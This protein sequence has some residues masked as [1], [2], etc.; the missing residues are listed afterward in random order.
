MSDL[1]IEVARRQLGMATH[2]YLRDFDPVSVHCLA[3]AGCELMHFCARKLSCKAL[4]SLAKL[5]PETDFATLRQL[6]R[7]YWIAFKH[8]TELGKPDEERDDDELLRQFMDEKNDLALVIGWADYHRATGKIPIEAQVQQ[9]WYFALH[10]EKHGA[11]ELAQKSLIA[12]P[13][14]QTKSR[15]EQKRLLNVWIRRA[16]A[17]T[18]TMSHPV[19][20]QRPLGAGMK[21]Q[22]AQ[23][24]ISIDAKPRSQRDRNDIAIEVGGVSQAQVSELRV[25]V[26]DLQSGEVTV[27]G[28]QAR[29]WAALMPL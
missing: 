26:K 23:F 3:N 16:R 2:L 13:D 21:S 1:K 14:L 5:A 11:P 25:V 17:N 12:F 8:A 4:L 20:E 10:P 22:G 7:Q 24:E 15:T 19:T 18:A 27:G 6:Q 29:H 9:A 28:V